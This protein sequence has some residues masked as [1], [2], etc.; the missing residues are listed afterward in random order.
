[1]IIKNEPAPIIPPENPYAKW[2]TDW[3]SDSSEKYA[4]IEFENGID[5]E[6]I[7]ELHR[8]IGNINALVLA[9]NSFHGLHIS[10]GF[11]IAETLRGNKIYLEKM[12]DEVPEGDKHE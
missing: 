12:T 4:A 10:Y 6:N 1:M 11:G 3:I 2:F 7:S 5:Y 8:C 9:F